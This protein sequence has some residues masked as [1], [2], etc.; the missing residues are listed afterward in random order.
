M[1][2]A[3]LLKLIKVIP[4]LEKFGV[5]FQ[6]VPLKRIMRDLTLSLHCLKYPLSA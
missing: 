6:K 5:I 3:I 4:Y 2:A 1:F